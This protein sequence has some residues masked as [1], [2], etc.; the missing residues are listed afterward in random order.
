MV[1]AALRAAVLRGPCSGW[2]KA[3]LE[4]MAD[5][6][7]GKGKRDDHPDDHDHDHDHDHGDHKHG[8]VDPVR[9]QDAGYRLSL[10]V[11]S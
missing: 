3:W 4:S 11:M 6:R 5:G 9:R 7:H 10:P 1:R 2:S 8:Y